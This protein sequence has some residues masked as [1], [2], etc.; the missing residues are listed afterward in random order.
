MEH[1]DR[2]YRELLNEGLR[3]VEPPD[4]MHAKVRGGISRNVVH[5]RHRNTALGTIAIAIVATMVLSSV[6]PVFGHNGT[7]PQVITAMAAERQAHKMTEALGTATVEQT[8]SVLLV[9]E[10]T[11]QAV[12]DST[13]SETDSILALVI[14]DRAGKPVGEVIALRNQGLGWGVIMA[15]LGISGHD[16]SEAVGQ[17]QALAVAGT[18]STPSQGNSTSS[19]PAV[20]NK[21]GDKVVVNGEITAVVPVGVP[22]ITVD[23]K[24]FAIVADTQLKYHGKAVTPPEILTKLLAGKLYATVQGTQLADTTLWANLIIV[25]DA[26]DSTEQGQEEPEQPKTSNEQQ[27]RGKVILVVPLSPA[28]PTILRVEGFDHDIVLN[29]ATKVEWAGAGKVT[30]AD[31]AV[32]Q[33]VQ[34]HVILSGTTYTAQQVHIETKYVKPNTPSDEGAE[35]QGNQPASNEQQVRGNVTTVSP[36]LLQVSGFAPGIVLNSSTKVEQVGAGKSTLADIKAG[37]T[38][39][40]HVSVSGGIYT[41]TQVHIETKY[42]KPNN[43]KKPDTAGDTEGQTS[44]QGNGTPNQ[45]A[46]SN[47]NGDKIVVNGEIAGISPISITVAGKTFAIVTDTQLKYHGKTILPLEI[48]AKLPAEKLYA[49]VQGTELSDKSLRANLVI[50]QDGADSTEDGQQEEQQ[51]D[52]SIKTWQ[53]TIGTVILPTASDLGAIFVNG[54]TGQPVLYRM[55]STS[56]LQGTK[57]NSGHFVLTLAELVAGQNVTIQG[58]LLADGTVDIVKLTVTTVSTTTTPEPTNPGKGKGSDKP[59]KN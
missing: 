20:S 1:D 52:P 4:G 23:G 41:A 14:A 58:K 27:I 16:I 28:V 12:A 50:I 26:P 43:G 10:A 40:V 9:P 18:P 25:Q 55:T 51:T 42:E 48:L 29:A 49:T 33:V 35:Q 36:T 5:M 44:S 53:G 3:N 21:N 34:V 37:Q 11:V 7:L 13:L 56:V 59:G 22:S 32:S 46:V 24:T 8:S 31:I 47:K 54:P 19:Q 15:Q 6:T 45:P 57:T 38:V 2:E 30:L 39:Q 17:A